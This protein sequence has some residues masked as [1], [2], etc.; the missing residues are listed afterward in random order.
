MNHKAIT[1][2]SKYRIALWGILITTVVLSQV[3]APMASPAKTATVEAVYPGLATGVLKSARLVSL[4]KGVLLE[5]GTVLIDESLLK[6]TIDDADPKLREQLH[7][8]LFFILEKQATQKILFRQAADAG[9]VVKGHANQIVMMYLNDKASGVTVSDA[10]AKHFYDNNKEMIGSISFEQ[11]KNSVE[12]YLLQ[13]KKH[14]AIEKYIQELGQHIEI[15]IDS[16]WVKNQNALAKDN[17]VDIVRSSGKPTMV[18]FGATGC[19]P[20]D[21]MQ[22]IL[23]NLRKKYQNNLNVLFVH[24]REEQILAARYGIRSIPVQV[25]FDKAG[26][27]VFRHEGFYPEAEI[28]KNLVTMGVK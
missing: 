10:E 4:D 11:A 8:N 15:R 2:V 22:P 14:A 18:E 25:F 6:K 20:C 1:A 5:A 24:V 9:Y 16:Q 27:E 26:R 21:M 17:P 19:I 7:K 13:Q 28:T 23:A 12:N 3:S